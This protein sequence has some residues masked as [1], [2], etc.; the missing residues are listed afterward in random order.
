MVRSGEGDEPEWTE[1][2]ERKEE[3]RERESKDNNER[4]SSDN[5]PSAGKVKGK[6]SKS[7][8]SKD[9]FVYHF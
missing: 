6:I 7:S 3:E 2:E 4:Y 9:Y 5:L 1:E 8:L